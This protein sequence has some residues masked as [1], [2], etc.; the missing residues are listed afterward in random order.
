M[1]CTHC[2]YSYL[3]VTSYSLRIH[4]AIAFR[5]ESLARSGVSL[6]MDLTSSFMRPRSRR[7]LRPDPPAGGGCHCQT[8]S[9]VNHTA[10]G[11]TGG[12][13]AEP[14]YSGISWTALAL[15][16]GKSPT[17]VPPGRQ[18]PVGV[19]PPSGSAGDLR[20]HFVVEP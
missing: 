12:V 11:D 6:L 9:Y 15:E 17:E 18:L 5:S 16:V 14:I 10:Y 3:G 8:S 4:R 19:A 20:V 2:S 1:I 7:A 13:R